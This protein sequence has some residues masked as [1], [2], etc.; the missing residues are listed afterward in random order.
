MATMMARTRLAA[1]CV[2]LFA[3]LL[4]HAAANLACVSCK[5]NF[6]G[7]YTM[8]RRQIQ[9]GG[10]ARFF[11]IHKANKI[12]TQ[13]VPLIIDIHGYSVPIYNDLLT[14]GASLISVHGSGMKGQYQASGFRDYSAGFAHWPDNKGYTVVYPEGTGA[15]K[16]W[17][18]G[19]GCCGSAQS[20]GKDDSGFIRAI[21]EYMINTQ[22]DLCNVDPQRIYLTG[23]SNGCALA[24]RVA[25]ESSDL[26]AAVAC[27]GMYRLQFPMPASGSWTPRPIMEIH[28]T[29]D[30]VIAYHNFARAWP[31]GA[32][33][34][35]RY[36]A[37]D[38]N[39]MQSFTTSHTGFNKIHH[40][41]CANGAEVQLMT[42]PGARHWPYKNMDTPNICTTCSALG[43][44]HRFTLA[45]GTQ[46]TTAA[47]PSSPPCIEATPAVEITCAAAPTD[48]GGL[49]VM[50]GAGG[51]A[52]ACDAA[53]QKYARD[54]YCG[55][56]IAPPP[57]PP[58]LQ[59][60]EAEYQKV[61]GHYGKLVVSCP[62]K[63]TTGFVEDVKLGLPLCPDTESEPPEWV[64]QTCATFQCTEYRAGSEF[65]QTFV[66]LVNK[67]WPGA[68][69]S[70]VKTLA[71][72]CGT[73]AA[74]CEDMAKPLAGI[75][76]GE[77]GSWTCKQYKAHYG[78]GDGD[79]CSEAAI[80]AHAKCDGGCQADPGFIKS[81]C[82][83]S[84]QLCPSKGSKAAP[85]SAPPCIE[86]TP[87][88]E[89]TCAAPPTD[90]GG[91]EVMLGAGGCASACDAAFQKY[92]RD[93]YCGSQTA[94][95]ESTAATTSNSNSNSNSNV[96][97]NVNV[98]SKNGAAG[99]EPVTFADDDATPSGVP[100]SAA[101][102]Y[103]G[104]GATL[105]MVTTLALAAATCW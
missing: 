7:D 56:Q 100:A 19:P 31:H 36:L 29:N 15:D 58:K 2:I 38:F 82:T 46:E 104:G 81:R 62:K 52:S 4:G 68:G 74:A 39:C 99:S 84:C 3:V 76:E 18:A 88:V 93:L 33:E 50:L 91:L 40:T 85:P 70:I 49:E 6:F 47:P 86:A 64:S 90:C 1:P 57:P 17:N 32:V 61:V 5:K 73:G 26:V 12:R 20:A 10:E 53:F 77:V 27:M 105:G 101:V 28:G 41:Q 51:C 21:I 98:N 89:I 65:T 37:R 22:S 92:A 63:C 83:R 14:L 8:P 43:F 103:R 79:A 67:C 13:K 80:K 16:S 23:H 95:P 78:L 9:H 34:N 102:A 66:P 24:Q 55:S 45:G 94:P 72:A 97:V 11:N 71:A 35:A 48:C 30:P 69:D 54:L 42:I 59:C 75:V 96:N 25:I 60:S 87:A 44:L